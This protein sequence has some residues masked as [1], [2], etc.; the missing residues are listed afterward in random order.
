MRKARI[1]YANYRRLANKAHG[2][3]SALLKSLR[4]Q[5]AFIKVELRYINKMERESLRLKKHTPRYV[6]IRREVIQMRAQV[7]K[8]IND[9][10]RA[11]ARIR[12]GTKHKSRISK[13][14]LHRS[15]KSMRHFENVL[16]SYKARQHALK[17][18]LIRAQNLRHINV[19]GKRT[20]IQISNQLV[21]LET[22]IYNSFRHEIYPNFRSGYFQC[23]SSIALLRRKYSRMRCTKN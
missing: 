8:E 10:E 11:Y 22:H 19:I 18:Q 15:R 20:L 23:R 17:I 14:R 2:N 16:R 13:N 9:V 6:E 21:Q 7:H 5:R 1:A 12:N 4:R 3:D